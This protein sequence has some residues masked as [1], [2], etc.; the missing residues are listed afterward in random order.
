MEPVVDDIQDKDD[1]IINQRAQAFKNTLSRVFSNRMKA[2]GIGARL[3]KK[4]DTF[5]PQIVDSKTS[6][7]SDALKIEKSE[8]TQIAQQP[9]QTR[10][11]KERILPW[12]VENPKKHWRSTRKRSKRTTK[13][14]HVTNK[15]AAKKRNT[16]KKGYVCRKKLTAQQKRARNNA[17]RAR[18]KRDLGEKRGRE[19]SEQDKICMTVKEFM[20][21]LRQYSLLR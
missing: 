18:A 5:E 20:Q 8:P 13:Q 2:D 3:F 6:T 7:T 12:K 4:L 16:C 21:S 15:M 11:K 1:K 9:I 10:T 19:L 17:T 14:N